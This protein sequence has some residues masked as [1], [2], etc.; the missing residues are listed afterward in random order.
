MK[1]VD[2]INRHL[3][4]FVGIKFINENSSLQTGGTID[5]DYP[6]SSNGWAEIHEP[7][8]KKDYS[9]QILLFNTK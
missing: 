8:V 6:H 5:K 1:M 9:N 4:I 2:S 7:A 3:T